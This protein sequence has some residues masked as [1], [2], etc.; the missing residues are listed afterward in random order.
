MFLQRALVAGILAFPCLAQESAKS[1]FRDPTSGVVIQSSG[2][3]KGGRGSGTKPTA[4][5]AKPASAPAV[6]GLMYWIE[7]RGETGQL[8]RVNANR[9]FKT[10]E[11]IRLHVTSNVD[12]A[13]TIMQSQNNGPIEMLF[14]AR[15][16][17]DNRVRRFQERVFPSETGFFR[18]NSQTGNMRLLLMVQADGASETLLASARPPAS[19]QAVP[20]VPA[21]RPPQPA[22]PRR[23]PSAP[24]PTEAEFLAQIARSTGSKKLEIDDSPTEA[25]T[26]V[27]V[28]ARKNPDVTPGVV[29]VEVNL[30]QTGN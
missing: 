12:C 15:A 16:G 9:Q 21:P 18:F 6:T 27:V 4:A 5:A 13:L 17:A 7:L 1:L 3:K 14:P 10:G 25:A 23:S 8:L 28:D 26:Y 2:P 30:V 22:E 29:A 11:R 19:A 24:A 20:A